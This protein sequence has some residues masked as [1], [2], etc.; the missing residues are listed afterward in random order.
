MASQNH[1]NKESQNGCYWKEPL[2]GGL[3]VQPSLLKQGHLEPI[4]QDHVRTASEYLQGWR[5]ATSL[6]NLCQCLVTLIVK[7]C[8]LM[9]RENP[10]YFS[11]CPLPLVLSLGTTEK[12]LT[13]FS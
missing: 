4:A 5:P 1:K 10:L 13:L 6:V 2:S 7:Q 12:S 3:L 8:F 9:L 11:S